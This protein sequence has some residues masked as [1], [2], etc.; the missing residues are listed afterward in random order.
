MT[1]H[2]GLEALST[3]VDDELSEV[4][5]LEV[6]THLRSCDE[7]RTQLAGLQRVAGHLHRLEQVAAPSVLGWSLERRLRIEGP[8]VPFSR[9]L[10]DRIGHFMRQPHFAP[11]FA[12]VIAFGVILYVFSIGVSRHSASETR[13]VMGGAEVTETGEL[14]PKEEVV[15][16]VRATQAAPAPVEESEA[17]FGD[18]ERRTHEAGMSAILLAGREFEF[19][20]GRWTE[21]GLAWD[22]PEILIDLSAGGSLPAALEELR[23]RSGTY[24][25]LFEGRVI[26]VVVPEPGKID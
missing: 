2:C 24:R 22:E 20:E 13:V 7:C 17:L 12:L 25:L 26:E 19:G 9:R 23:S 8:R 4:R 3:Y 10:E 15:G 11:L 5:R 6:E 14:E 18:R 16:Q 1:V 21:R